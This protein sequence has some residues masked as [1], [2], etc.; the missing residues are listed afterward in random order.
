MD[1]CSDF[2]EYVPLSADA[3]ETFYHVHVCP[4]NYDFPLDGL[5]AFVQRSHILMGVKLSV[6]CNFVS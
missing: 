1:F 2:P 5:K 6:W 4:Y 3:E